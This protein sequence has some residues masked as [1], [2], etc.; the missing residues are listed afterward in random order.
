MTNKPR[1]HNADLTRLPPA[2]RP[3]T[4]QERWVVW[5]WEM[6]KTKSAEK[7]TKPPRQARNPNRNAL[8]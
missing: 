3:L 7:W 8:E 1:T 4:E 2:L 6:R 5:D